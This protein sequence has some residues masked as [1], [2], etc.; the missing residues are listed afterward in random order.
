MICFSTASVRIC[1]FLCQ[2][3][4]KVYRFGPIFL[5]FATKNI[6]CRFPKEWFSHGKQNHCQQTKDFCGQNIFFSRVSNT[7]GWGSHQP[8]HA[9]QRSPES[10]APRNKR[11]F[12]Y[13]VDG[14]GFPATRGYLLVCGWKMMTHHQTWMV[15]NISWQIHSQW[16]LSGC[17]CAEQLTK[18]IVRERATKS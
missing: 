5:G 17:I 3:T 14:L 16:N 2:L 6:L 15:C 9:F 12:C 4:A 1:Y 10:V 11:G 18:E 7:Q 13:P 8:S